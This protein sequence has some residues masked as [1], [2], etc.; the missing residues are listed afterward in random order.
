[1]GTYSRKKPLLESTLLYLIILPPTLRAPLWKVSLIVKIINWMISSPI[2]AITRFV[3]RSY[4]L[5][6]KCQFKQVNEIS[7]NTIPVW[8][9]W[10]QNCSTCIKILLN[11]T[12]NHFMKQS[13]IFTW[14]KLSKFHLF[15]CQY[16]IKYIEL[17]D[18]FSDLTSR[19]QATEYLSR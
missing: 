9:E 17:K 14:A 4:C 5:L 13:Q 2:I 16:M 10:I 18:L 15:I 3:M 6:T 12:I 11:S 1:M 7:Y 19:T 8:I